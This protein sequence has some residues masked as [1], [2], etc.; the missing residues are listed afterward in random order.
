MSKVLQKKIIEHADDSL[1]F[2]EEDRDLV[3]LCWNE[4][5]GINGVSPNMLKCLN[6]N[7]KIVLLEI[8]K[9]WME[10]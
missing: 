1:S 3:K 2:K 9:E 8:F 6:Y 4:S 7:H 10:N 5:P